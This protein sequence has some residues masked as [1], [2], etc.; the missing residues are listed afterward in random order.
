MIEHKYNESTVLLS[1]QSAP[2]EV[3]SEKNLQ[4]VLFWLLLK[5]IKLIHKQYFCQDTWKKL[6]LTLFIFF[7][8]LLCRA[9]NS[10]HFF[11]IPTFSYSARFTLR[12]VCQKKPSV[13]SALVKNSDVVGLSSH[14]K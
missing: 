5:S 1:Y 8:S 3:T 9:G 11:S 4:M 2:T 10:D 12:A 13:T 14:K 6:N 7:F